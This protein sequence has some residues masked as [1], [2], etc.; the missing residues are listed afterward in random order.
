MSEMGE[1]NLKRINTM[2]K[3]KTDTRPR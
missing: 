1:K 2:R 3:E